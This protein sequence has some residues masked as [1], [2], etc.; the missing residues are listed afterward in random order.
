MEGRGEAGSKGQGDSGKLPGAPLPQDPAGPLPA[1]LSKRKGNTD[2][3]KNL[4]RTFI[5]ALFVSAPN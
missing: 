1:D 2:S 5:A 4:H 3:H